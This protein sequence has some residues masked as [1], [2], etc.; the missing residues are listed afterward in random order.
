MKHI[1]N[2]LPLIILLVVLTGCSNLNRSLIFATHTTVGLEIAISPH[3]S[4]P[5]NIII[6]Y[7]RSESVINPVYDKKG[8]KTS[9]KDTNGNPIINSNKYRPEAY[10]VIA[11]LSGKINTD[12]KQAAAAEMSG[13][14]WFATGK[15][16]TKLAEQPGIAGAV[17]GS[18]KI[19]KE[20]A[21]EL[22]FGSKFIKTNQVVA[23]RYLDVLYTSLD[24]LK[25]NDPVAGGHLNALNKL[26]EKYIT[27]YDFVIYGISINSKTLEVKTNK[28]SPVIGAKNF[29]LILE[30]NGKLQSSIEALEFMAKSNKKMTF[31]G[32]ST[33]TPV[34]INTG[35]K[36]MFLAE[37]NNQKELRQSFQQKIGAKSVVID[38]ANYLSSQL[39]N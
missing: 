37:S 13:A 30:Y 22:K 18:P 19:A 29:G 15:A 25:N 31:K 5:V 16:A 23:W 6:G 8:T 2:F 26:S 34:E 12:A 36:N 9:A 17:S 33:D 10:S 27:I 35:M 14:Q 39:I 7:K 20:A 24:T 4:N 38:A 32:S 28:D 1:R 11:K 3:E 21:N